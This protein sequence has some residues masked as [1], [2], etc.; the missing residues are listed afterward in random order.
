MEDLFHADN[1]TKK[2]EEE[3]VLEKIKEEYGFED[4]KEVFDERNDVIGG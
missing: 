4:I 1:I 2:E 3:L